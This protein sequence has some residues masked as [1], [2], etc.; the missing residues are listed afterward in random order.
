MSFHGL[1]MLVVA[2][3]VLLSLTSFL[4]ILGLGF[5]LYLALR[6]AFHGLPGNAS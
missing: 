1:V 6:I 3:H 4:V 2:L 5:F